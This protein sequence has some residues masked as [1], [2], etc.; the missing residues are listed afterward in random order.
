[1]PAP[2]TTTALPA[3]RTTAILAIICI[4]YFMVILDNSIMFTGLPRI[5]SAMGFSPSGLTWVQDAYTLV[6]GGLLLLGAR[7]GDIAGRRRM[8]VIGLVLFGLASFLV[9]A[10]P[11]AWWLIRHRYGAYLVRMLYLGAMM[12]FFFFTTQYLQGILGFTPCRPGSHS[13]R[14]PRSTS[15]SRCSSPAVRCFGSTALLTAGVAA[16]LA[17][18]AWLSRVGLGTSY[19]SAVALPMVLIGTGQGLA[20]APMTSAGLAGVDGS[21]AG[22]ASGLIN[23]FHQLGSALGLGILVAVGAAGVP[24]GAPATAALADRVST[25]LTGGSIMLAAALGLTIVLIAP[26]RLSA[27][28]P[29]SQPVAES[30]AT[31]GARN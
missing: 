4:S 25:A 31:V 22:A 15:R 2:R 9:G 5:E 24:V 8:F 17:G 29:T 23:T 13:C 12:G 27:R 30:R 26:R 1:V 16:T 11:A 14:C 21:D 28:R 10:A 3:K 20:F 6:F 18:M 19:L 7:A